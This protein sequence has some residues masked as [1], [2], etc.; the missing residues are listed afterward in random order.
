M[1]PA[2]HHAEWLQLVPHTGP[3]LTLPVLQRVFPQQL[4]ALESGLRGHLRDALDDWREQ[5]ANP[6]LH[7]AWI[8]HVLKAV[9]RHTDEVL[10]EG[11]SIPPGLEARQLEHGEVLRPDFVLLN[12]AG[13]PEPS[14]PRLLLCVHPPGTDLD[15]PLPDRR[16]KASPSSRMAELCHA[17][18]VPLGLVTNG[19]HWLLVWAPRGETTGYASWFAQLWSEEPLTFRAFISLLRASRFFAVAPGDTLEALYTESSRDQSEVTNQL[20]LQVRQAVQVLIQSLDRLDATQGRTLLAGTS[21]KELYNAALTVMMRLVFLFCAEEKGLLLLGNHL[22]DEHYAVSTLREQLRETA[23]RHGEELLESRHDAWCRLLAIFRAIHGGIEHDELRLP[24]YG[25][26]LFD[27]DRYPFLEG[28]AADTKWQSTPAHPLEIN[29][30]VVLHLLEA[31]QTLETKLPGTSERQ[32][33]RLSFRALDIEQIGHVYEGLLDHTAKRAREVVLGL[34]GQKGEEPEIPLEKL[35]EL[36]GGR[37]LDP[38]EGSST[39][40]PFLLAADALADVVPFPAKK[41]Q[42]SYSPPERLVEFLHE[43][44]GRSK[45]ALKKA[46]MDRSRVDEGKLRIACGNDDSLV[47]RVTPFA[48]LLR[49]DTFGRPLVFPGGSLYVTSGSDRRST[50]THY[51]PRSLTEPIV[52]HTLEPLVYLGPAEVLPKE[53][54]KL[55]S[56]KE[57][58]ALKVCDMAMGSGA[59]LVQTCRYL[60]ERLMEAWEQTEKAQPGAF[61]TTPEGDLST[62]AVTERLLPADPA[63]RL[64][65]ARRYVADRC[66]YGL[67]INPMAVEM[68]KLSLWLITLQR[69]RPF[70]FLDHALKCGDSLLGVSSVHQIENFSLRPGERQITF[71]TADLAKNVDEASDKRRALEDLPSND[72]TQIETKNRLHAEAE[73]ATAKVKAIADCLI[74]LELRGLDGDAYEEQRTDEAE[75]VQLLMKRDADASLKSQT[76]TINQLSAHACEQLRG[77]RTFHWAVEFPEVFARGGFDAFVGNPPFVGGR[78]IRETLGDEYR[79]ALYSIYPASSGNADLSAFFFLRAFHQLREGGVFGLLATNTIAQGDTRLTGLDQIHAAG[80]TIIR[81]TNNMPWP[82]QAAVVVNLV[83]VAKSEATP[84]FILDD[85]VVSGISTLLVAEESVS[86]PLPLSANSDHSFQGSV[87]AGIGFVLT[88][89]EADALLRSDKRNNEIVCPFLNGEDLNGNPD[90]S[91]SR[92]VI[93]FYDWPLAKAESYADAMAIVRDRVYPVRQTVNREAHRKYWWHYG[94]KRPALY[95]AIRDMERV[96]VVAATSRTLA[97][98]FLPTRMVFSHATYVFAFDDSGHF[99]ALQ[100][101]FHEIWARRFASSMKGDLRYTPTD[102]FVNFPF[103]S[104]TASLDPIGNAYHEH[105]RQVTL[106]RQEGLTKTYNRFHDRGEQ[107]ADIARLRALHV[108]MD[109]AVAAA[110][111]WSDLDLGHGFHPTKQGERYTLSEPARRTVLD[112]LLALNHQRYAE[113]VKAGLHE[114]RAAKTK[115]SKTKVI[116]PMAP[117]AG[118]EFQFGLGLASSA[119][120]ERELPTD[121]RLPASDGAHYAVSLVF[122]LLSEA[123]GKLPLPQLRDA[124]VLATSPT[125][126]QRL[127]PAQDVSRVKA[128]AQRWR[129]DAKP[130]LFIDCLKAIGSRHLT[131]STGAGGRVFQLLDAPRPPSNEDVGYDAWLALRV[132]ATL[133]PSGIL[134]P[135]APA[136]TRQAEELVLA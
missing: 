90:Q 25:G 37:A 88:H 101:A 120:V 63:E 124:F 113:E 95:S 117:S 127:A 79:A 136:M 71:A 62:G 47:A 93:N 118:D 29:N 39:S 48:G 18:N 45:S 81:A 64:A 134:I 36:A 84:P 112:R 122:A 6:A 125:L 2:S 83:H 65:I 5:P 75:K 106:S 72:H 51:T 32:R 66:L 70:T 57:L 13:H 130:S 68:A 126:M 131:V 78:R 85:K 30:R 129:E 60:A 80:G 16:W 54:W 133:P 111:G 108:E 98:C 76:P 132:S 97:F 115:R 44:S 92:L 12:P 121:M 56:A 55:K 43:A 67:D 14:K 4:E 9:L 23:D 41:G 34:G 20:G 27:P 11:Q 109:Q 42:T 1:S 35:E 102:C 24:A 82:G 119:S 105:R 135:E 94:D 91:P 87:L 128:W 114:K 28:R 110:Y 15:K 26:S 52:Q 8:L 104:A 38:L 99:A 74:A 86:E 31:L 53:Q 19:D 3:F 100:S 73:A 46:L 40:E 50:G 33:L 116:T 59:F 89:E 103:P 7:R 61:I 96:I 77:R 58:L 21:E 69:D 10:V 107:S 22:Y 123:G 49:E 17:A